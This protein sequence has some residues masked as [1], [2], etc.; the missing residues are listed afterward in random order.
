[1]IT[2]IIGYPLD[3]T[4]SPKMHNA[5]FRELGMDGIYLR[6]PVKAENLKN[7]VM[8]LAAL[9]FKGANVTIPYKEKVIEYLD[10]IATE[11]RKV[12]AVNTILIE[13]DKLKGFNT[14]IY[15]FHKSLIEYDVIIEDK[16]LLLIG[17]GGVAHACAYVINTLKPERFI[18]TDKII[19]R[20]NA[21]SDS[22]DAEV[23][24]PNN[25]ENIASEMDVIINATPIDFQKSLLPVLKQGSVY[26][27][28]NYKYKSLHK[29]NVKII[30]GSLM[31][32][33][34]GARSFYLWMGKEAPID[35]MKKAVGL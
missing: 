16:A 6:L 19:E 8:G 30:N 22:F 25:I 33:L 2:G 23:I 12:G 3:V 18:I 15:G 20:A 24:D 31:L 17:A 9:G 21:I 13:N 4:L 29:K 14:D 34:Q 11:A 32:M 27:D 5:A 7:A 1:M 35:V 28:L 10:E 26:Y